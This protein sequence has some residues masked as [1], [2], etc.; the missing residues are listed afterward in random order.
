M[1]YCQHKITGCKIVSLTRLKIL[2]VVTNNVCI[3][4]ALLRKINSTA[5]TEINTGFGVNASDYGGRFLNKDGKANLEK[6]GIGFLEK[7]S[8]Y[9][10]LLAL[11][12]WK[13][14]SIIFIF[15]IAI[16][17]FFRLSIIS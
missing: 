9:H 11:P 10:S 17:I 1:K 6:R 2:Y 8:W 3:N 16:N 15:F 13:F 12:R 4:M 7:I 5:K 14:F